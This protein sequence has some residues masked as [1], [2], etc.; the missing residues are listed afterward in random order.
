MDAR[1]DAGAGSQR[2]PRALPSPPMSPSAYLKLSIA[3]A[4]ATLA[5]K[6]GAWA[7]SGAVSLL[8]DAL[9][10]LVNLAGALF[11]L[12]M[13][14]VA[15]R[16]PDEDHPY[17]HDKA[18]S[19]SA[20][21]EGVLILAAALGI[22]AA[23]LP[24]L[25]DPRPLDPEGLGWGLGLGLAGSLLNLVLAQA[26]RRAARRERSATLDAGARH[27]MVDVWTT[28]GVLAGLLA[29][30]ATGWLWLDPALAL[31]LAVPIGREGLGLLRRSVDTLMDAR[32]DAG[33][34]AALERVLASFARPGQVRF[35]HLR[36]RR[37]G[38][39]AHLD[40]H[41]HLP[42][43]WTLG[44]AAALRR[45]V[46]QAL[47]AARPGL[48][49]SIQLLPLGVETRLDDPPGPDPAGLRGGA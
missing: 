44:Q 14:S 12:A 43:A 37:A 19:F 24:R 22:A 47:I 45:E 25:L 35:D 41:L 20:G 30:Q 23:A 26:M 15:A 4:L 9:E 29:V 17:G 2:A 3:V 38:A 36:S 27:L 6:A 49:P 7:F 13:V 28:A 42:A 8:S 40:V 21:F 32:L 33:E 11:G 5:L 31:A 39:S 48:R 18:E 16:P 1:H 34:Q 10:S 46:E